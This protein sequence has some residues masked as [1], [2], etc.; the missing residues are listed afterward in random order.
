MRHRKNTKTLGRKKAQREALMRNLADSL[1]VHGKIE[2]TLAKAKELRKFI[3]PLV[4]KAKEP[5]LA[6]RRELIRVL[7]TDT[8]IKRMMEEW[9]PKY[10]QRPGGYTR[11]T[12][13]GARLNDGAEMAVIEFVD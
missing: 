10:K 4:T 2:T 12:K 7:Y 6:S 13:I 8:A 9:G 11:I 3:E 5:S 1:A